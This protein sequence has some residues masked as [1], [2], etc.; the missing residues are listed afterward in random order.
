MSDA[1]KPIE[2]N[3][4]KCNDFDNL[5]ELVS[6]Y[7]ETAIHYDKYVKDAR[8]YIGPEVAAS[9]T[10][11]FLKSQG[12][13]EDCRILDVGSG[14]GLQ[15]EGLVKHGFT[16]IDAL[17]PSEKSHEVARKKNLYKNYI[18]DYLEP[19]RKLNIS[20][21]DYDA[22]AC[23][24][25]FTKGHV[26]AEAAMDEMVRVVRAEGLVC[27]TIREDVMFDTE[28]G[29][30]AKMAEL[31]EKKYW[32]LVSHSLEPYHLAGNLEKCHMFVYKVC[33]H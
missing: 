24:G 25:V 15:A 10:A 26:T 11:K 32:E 5:K 20:D 14:T 1:K 17:D 18:T 30:E 2:D 21:G 13:S 9:I 16:N 28:Y 7:D 4:L 22:V 31:C 23:V 19:G 6:Y 33:K 3:V 27:F 12:F 8:G 29:Y